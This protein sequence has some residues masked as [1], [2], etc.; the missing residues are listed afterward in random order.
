MS[1]MVHSLSLT[2]RFG[3]I[4][5]LAKAFVQIK[6]GNCAGT[7]PNG[8]KVQVLDNNVWTPIQVGGASSIP[9]SSSSNTTEQSTLPSPSPTVTPTTT[10]TIP[11]IGTG[12]PEVSGSRIT[13]TSQVV[14]QIDQDTINSNSSL[15]SLPD[16]MTS[17]TT[18][19]DT[20]SSSILT[21]S[22]S[23]SSTIASEPDNALQSSLTVTV[24]TTP[25]TY[26]TT[27]ITSSTS[28]GISITTPTD[29]M[30]KDNSTSDTLSILPGTSS[31]GFT[32][33]SGASLASVASVAST[34]TVS[35]MA[36]GSGCNF[37]AW[38]CSGLQLQVC[39]YVTTTSLGRLSH[40][41]SVSEQFD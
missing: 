18:N 35:G 12:Q 37:G 21:I 29:G 32:P 8:L 36:N 5:H 27:T 10:T 39:N 4:K 2:K 40:D 31:I 20:G 9:G 6:G 38:Q 19:D 15:T 11:S 33:S 26:T 25:T 14:C 41:N 1:G 23:S 17:T 3:I 13:T 34:T 24:Y 7:N 16:P 28:P 30:V 22:P